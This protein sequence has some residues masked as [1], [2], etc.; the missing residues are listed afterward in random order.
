MFSFRQ[1][2]PVIRLKR[3]IIAMPAIHTARMTARQFLELG[4]DP[5]GIRLELVD[6]EIEMA[7]SPVPDHSHIDRMLT[8][9][10]LA[11]ILEHDL[12][13]LFGNVDTVF[14]QH[15]VRRPDI[16]FFAK[17]RLHLVGEKAMEGPP[18]L[19]VE[20]VSPSS[21]VIDREVKYKLY[22]DG[23]VAHYWIVDPQQ[24]SFEAFTLIDGAYKLTAKATGD[25]TMSAEPFADLSIPLG[26]LWRKP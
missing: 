8:H 7:P 19:C 1:R 13:K 18:D 6:G 23:G 14:N 17:D 16:I 15:N 11:H 22:Q 26:D 3:I 5:P 4:E 12:G 21:A 25:E 24:R 20:I 10:M 2:V 9:F